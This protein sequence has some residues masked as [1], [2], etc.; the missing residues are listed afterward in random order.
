MSKCCNCGH[1]Q[2]VK[3]LKIE[4]V[5]DEWG[6][7]CPCEWGSFQVVGRDNQVAG[8]RKIT[9]STEE[10]NVLF[11]N[12][13]TRLLDRFKH[14]DVRWSLRGQGTQCQWDTMRGAGLLVINQEYFHDWPEDVQNDAI[15][16]FLKAFNAWANGQIFRYTIISE[17]EVVDDCGGFYDTESL[18][19]TIMED[20]MYNA[21]HK[22]VKL[23]G[24]AMF[25][26]EDELEAALKKAGYT[27]VK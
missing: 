20:G 13:Q 1:D 12:K 15:Q 26:V 27:I 4:V 6:T 3:F 11:K 5:Y 2:E 19:E 14:G 7:E 18:V 10:L 23:I 17:G 25:A 24:N 8:D 9:Y 16:D 21:Y 22:Q